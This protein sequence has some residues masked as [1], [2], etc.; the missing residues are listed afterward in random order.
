MANEKIFTSI[1][2]AILDEREP[3]WKELDLKDAKKSGED[4]LERTHGLV[5]TDFMDDI[6]ESASRHTAIP[7]SKASSLLENRI[8]EKESAMSNISSVKADWRKDA[9]RPEDYKNSYGDNDSLLDEVSM[10]FAQA[11]SESTVAKKEWTDGQIQTYVKNLLNQ[12]MSPSK[13]A[14]KLEK[15]AELELFNHQMSTDYL[16]RN[17][18]MMG[19]A[20]LEPNTYMDK[21]NPSYKHTAAEETPRLVNI[22]SH[23]L[24]HDGNG[25]CKKCGMSMQEASKTKCSK[26]SSSNDCVRQ[27]AAW[28]RE[29][30]KPQAKSVKQ[31]KACEDCQ[32]FKKDASGKRCNLYHLPI[33]ANAQEL[34][35]IVNNLT[36]GVPVKQK[37]AALVQIANRADQHVQPVTFTSQTNLMKTADA[38][39]DNQALRVQPTAVKLYSQHVAKLHD[40]GVTLQQIYTWASKKFGSVDVS[41]AMRGFVQSLQKDAHGRVVV[42]KQDLAFL[43]SIG[44]RSEAFQASAKCASCP[45][46]FGREAKVENERGAMRVDQKFSQRT[47][48]V[49]RN[50]K[51]AAPEVEFTMSRARTLHQAGHSVEKIFNGAAAKVGSLQARKVIAEYV[52]NLKRNPGKIAVSEKDR[53]FLIGKLS[54]KPEVFRTLEPLRRPTNK[55]VSST[56]ESHI[57]GYPGMEKQAGE[58]KA[59]DGHAILNEYDLQVSHD[60]EIDMK[61]P[62]RLDVRM[63][64]SFKLED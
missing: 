48:D 9:S 57:L 3:N 6:A 22:R 42:A 25:S 47:P 54:F 46:H 44:I 24:D 7:S 45:T 59:T 20:Y 28:Q 58:H 39:V 15:L 13:V 49:I 16:Q 38:K 60:Q 1:I 18:G 63:N 41:I 33:V 37:R 52:V 17:A 23:E 19:L 64:A 62:E 36:P 12:G 14:A 50:S 10:T 43:N 26:S 34:S 51:Q 40:K 61:E 53:A 2:D 21:Q 32:F 27:Q 56:D 29:G 11:E 31:I 30:I 4:V 8:A 55:V 35:Q 5:D